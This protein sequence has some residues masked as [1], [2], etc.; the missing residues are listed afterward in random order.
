MS[1]SPL[2]VNTP[3]HSVAGAKRSQTM[4]ARFGRSTLGFDQLFQMT[5]PAGP[6]FPDSYA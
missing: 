2:K 1:P 6:H 5:C 4:F 3:V